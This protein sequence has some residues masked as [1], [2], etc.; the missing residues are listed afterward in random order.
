MGFVKTRPTKKAG[1]GG[2]STPS[3]ALELSQCPD[4]RRH[5]VWCKRG[6]LGTDKQKRLNG[7]QAIRQVELLLELAQRLE[8]VNVHTNDCHGASD[9]GVEPV[10][11]DMKV[12][13]MARLMQ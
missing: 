9:V 13:R 3:G 12:G 2:G 7:L 11:L 5:L 10:L 4:S 6:L 1:E 8:S